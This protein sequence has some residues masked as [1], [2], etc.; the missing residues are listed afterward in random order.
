MKESAV[1]LRHEGTQSLKGIEKGVLDDVL[2]ILKQVRAS[3]G[4]SEAHDLQDPVAVAGEELVEGVLITA[5]AAW[6]KSRVF[7]WEPLA[8]PEAGEAPVPF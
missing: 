8:I 2:L 4:Q 7:L 3:P 1:R 5:R 6:R